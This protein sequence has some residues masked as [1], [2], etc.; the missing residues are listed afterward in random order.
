MTKARW[1]SGDDSSLELWLNDICW[2]EVLQVEG[3]WKVTVWPD[4]EPVEAIRPTRAEAMKWGRKYANFE[5]AD[6]SNQHQHVLDYY[7][8]KIDVTWGIRR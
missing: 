8:H 7:H 4:G 6:M 5:G 1:K 2:A 3:G